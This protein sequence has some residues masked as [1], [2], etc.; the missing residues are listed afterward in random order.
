LPGLLA[1]WSFDENAGARA[2]DAGA[3]GLHARLGGGRWVPGAR[4][5]AFWIT[6]PDS[7]AQLGEGPALDFPAGGPFTFTGWIRTTSDG[8]VLALRD[9]RDPGA[10]VMISVENGRLFFL[11]REDR[12]ERGTPA[13]LTGPVVAD[14]NWHHFAA[15]RNAGGGIEVF[16]DGESVGT[17]SAPH[18]GGP[19]TTDLRFVG[20]EEYRIRVAFRGATTWNGVIDELAAFGRQLTADEVAR[21]AGRR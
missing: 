6:G 16:V 18:G 21:L 12:M 15:T 13:Q 14:G 3:A 19:I 7:A 8:I 10:V 1:Y 4:G 11:V 5:S 9:G 20:R 17:N 2:A